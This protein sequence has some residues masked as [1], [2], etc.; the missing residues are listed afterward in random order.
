MGVDLDCVLV[1]YV[2][3]SA[4]LSWEWFTVVSCLFFLLQIVFG[5]IV[6]LMLWL[7]IR[8]I[9]SLLPNFLPYNVMLYRWVFEFGS[10]TNLAPLISECIYLKHSFLNRYW[11]SCDSCIFAILDYINISLAGSFS[12]GRLNYFSANEVCLCSALKCLL[13]NESMLATNIFY[14]KSTS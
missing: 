8:I 9:K 13:L 7:P 1:E 11:K 12:K 6:L 14:M 2:Q 10:F 5:S 3:K 4:C